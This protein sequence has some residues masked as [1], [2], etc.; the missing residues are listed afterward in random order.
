MFDDFLLVLQSIHRGTNCNIDDH[1]QGSYLCLFCATRLPYEPRPTSSHA[2]HVG[3]AS[4]RNALRFTRQRIWTP[5]KCRA[6]ARSE[7]QRV[8]LTQFPGYILGTTSHHHYNIS[9]TTDHDLVPAFPTVGIDCLPILLGTMDKGSSLASILRD[10][11]VFLLLRLLETPPRC[12]GFA[13]C[14]LSF[15]TMF[16]F[17]FRLPVND[18][19]TTV[20]YACIVDRFPER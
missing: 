12:Y 2:G 19:Q 7:T 18:Q 3:L 8:S 1:S 20:C 10:I 13:Y 16:A 9:F 15:R 11:S 5:R 17:L 14:T 4:C 6:C